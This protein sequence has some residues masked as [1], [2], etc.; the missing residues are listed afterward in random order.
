MLSQSTFLRK[1]I[2]ITIAI[3]LP[4]RANADAFDGYLLIG[5]SNMFGSSSAS[6]EF[7]PLP[8]DN[9]IHYS[10][11]LG[12]RVET[13]PNYIAN[14]LS[15]TDLTVLAPV[16][17][18]STRIRYGAE[19]DFARGIFR[20]VRDVELKRPKIAL[21]KFAV[22][23][24]GLERDWV[25]GDARLLQTLREQIAKF[26]AQMRAK[27]GVRIRGLIM[28]Q[29]ES[30]AATAAWSSKYLQNLE[31]LAQSIRSDLNDPNLPI[32]VTQIHIDN[33]GRFTCEIR[34]KQNEFVLRDAYAALVS[35]DH[36]KKN[37]DN[38]HFPIYEYRRLGALY[39]T[40]MP[41]LITRGASPVLD[42]AEIQ[43]K[44]SLVRCR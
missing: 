16:P 42:E 10:Y 34:K 39:S 37:L 9:Q 44:L 6:V 1:L 24:S 36:L 14:V 5:Q 11:F 15:S 41:A 38:P 20:Y 18:S 4:A 28:Y 26:R 13:P 29:G 8:P 21:L 22:G 17:I 7:S 35:V 23:S 33:E 30:D 12:T 43:K 40:E 3:C 27:G 31:I 2:L 32:L 19:I 25:G